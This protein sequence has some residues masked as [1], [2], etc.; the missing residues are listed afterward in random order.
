MSH[1]FSTVS[2]INKENETVKSVKQNPHSNT[3]QALRQVEPNKKTQ[4]DKTETSTSKEKPKEVHGESK[5]GKR[6]N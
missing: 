1:T 3:K 6:Q 4:D 5:V 2:T